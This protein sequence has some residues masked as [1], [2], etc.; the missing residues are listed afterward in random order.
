MNGY[1]EFDG[2]EFYNVNILK[3]LDKWTLG[4]NASLLD[5]KIVLGSG[6]NAT[7]KLD[8]EYIASS[9][10]RCKYRCVKAGIATENILSD[11]DS[12]SCDGNGIEII[13]NF[14]YAVDTGSGKKKQEVRK[15]LL[16]KLNS[17]YIEGNE[18]QF[19]FVFNSTNL[20]LDEMFECTVTIKNNNTSSVTFNYVELYRSQDVTQIGENVTWQMKI[21]SVKAYLDGMEIQFSDASEKVK[22]WFMENDGVFTGLNVNNERF[23]A[24]SRKNE[25]LPG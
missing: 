9:F 24:F 15:L 14:T 12:F 5:D 20:N 25:S 23:I 11:V 18:L 2:V 19:E 6:G 10:E 16:N 1:N 21:A 4:N 7:V 17:A 3:S 8:K 13:L 22:I